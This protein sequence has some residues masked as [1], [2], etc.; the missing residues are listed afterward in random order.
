MTET[1]WP[2]TWKKLSLNLKN[3]LLHSTPY[4]FKQG[5]L[6]PKSVYPFLSQ[7]PDAMTHVWQYTNK[8]AAWTEHT[9]ILS[10]GLRQDPAVVS[11]LVLRLLRAISTHSM[12]NQTNSLTLA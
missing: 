2:L 7:K 11:L 8:E 3:V 10:G 4:T 6:L 9:L 12:S 5:H 1:L